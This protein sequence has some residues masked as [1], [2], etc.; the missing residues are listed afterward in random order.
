[1][2]GSQFFCFLPT[3]DHFSSNWT[4]LVRGGKSHELLVEIVGVRSGHLGQSL[5]GLAM[6][7]DQACGRPDAAAFDQVGQDVVGRLG[8]QVGVEQRR[9]LAFGEAVLAGVAVEQADVA[10]L[11]VA[12]ADR[13]VSGVA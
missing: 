7:P 6:D 2:S 8:R 4:S 3:N 11:A 12:G 13:E 10:L 9:A 5:D 1:L